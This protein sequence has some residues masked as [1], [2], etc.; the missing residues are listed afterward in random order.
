[1]QN[2]LKQKLNFFA[3]LIFLKKPRILSTQKSK[4][5]EE[6]EVIR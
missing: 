3:K 6:A 4:G 1:M 5:S 2:N